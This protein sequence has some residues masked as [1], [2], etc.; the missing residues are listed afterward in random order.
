MQNAG[1]LV[2]YHTPILV[3]TTGPKNV[4]KGNK[5]VGNVNK[6]TTQT[7]DIL[8]SIL[9]PREWTEEGQL[10]VQYVSSTP[11]TR[12]DVVNLQE[13][14]DHQL[15]SRQA[16]ETGICPVREELYSQC[17]DELIRQI[18]IN[19]AERGLLLLRVRDEARMTIAAYETLY[20]SSIAYGIRKAL[21]AQQ[22][23]IE[24]DSKVRQLSM[25][26]R[27]LTQ[28]AESLRASIDITQSRSLERREAEEKTFAEEVERIQR[29]NEHLKVSLESMLSAPKK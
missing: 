17:F 10:W 21:M 29:T 2:K 4:K 1:S 3:N 8:N 9:P 12:L 16:R 27:E 28:Q 15:Q 25:S 6:Q 7:E 14:L 13:H 20:E 5:K 18:T 26:K 23:L 22:K 11:A 19:C 24:L